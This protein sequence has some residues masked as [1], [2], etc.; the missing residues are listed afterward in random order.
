MS[1]SWIRWGVLVFPLV[2]ASCQNNLPTR[3]LAVDKQLRAVLTYDN[4][5]WLASRCGDAVKEQFQLRDDA[6]FIAEA[7]ALMSKS[8]QSQVFIDAN[9]SVDIAATANE[10]AFFTVKTVNRLVTETERACNESDYDNIIVRAIGKNPLWVV[11]IAP[12]LLMLERV[13]QQPIGLAYVD[14]RLPDGQMSFSTEGNGQKIDIWITKE[15][16]VDEETEDVYARRAMLTVNSQ[17][18]QGCAYVGPA[19]GLLNIL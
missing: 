13:N 11:S 5:H 18:F 3:P 14:E 15:R 19:S 10:P 1:L 12:K 16:C 2:L 17:S 7:N 8:K 4:G 6:N 9:G